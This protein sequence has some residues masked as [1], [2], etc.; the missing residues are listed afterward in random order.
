V[1]LIT[2]T[3]VVET[4][5]GPDTMSGNARADI[6][7]GGVNDGGMD[8]MYGDRALPNPVTIANDGD[9]VLLGDNGLL[10]FTFDGFIEGV[11]SDFIEPDTDRHTLDLIHSKEDGKGGADNIS[12]DKGLD[13]A[14]G[15]TGGDTIYGDDAAASAAAF[16]LADILLGDNADIFLVDPE[17]ASGGDLKVVLDSAVKT[18]KT[19]DEE[20][21]EYG[22]PDTI[23]GNAKGDIIAGGVQGDTLYGDRQSPNPTTSADDGN[24]LI[25]GDNG[26]FE[27]LSNGR[28]DEIEGID[29]SANNPDLYAKFS[30]PLVFDDD[31][32]TL[33]LITTE[34]PTNGGRDAIW[35]DEGSDIV[36]G[37]TDLDTIHGDDGNEVAAADPLNTAA[38]PD[39]LFGDHGRLYPQF[40]RWL[41]GTGAEAML[42]EPSN[43]FNSRNFFA[44]D[45]GDLDGGEGDRMWGEE[46]DDIMVGQQGDDRMWGGSG[47]DD[48]IGGHNVSGGFD[49]ITTPAVDAALDG[50]SMNDL[51]DGG[52]GDDA[53]A[54][55]NTILWRRGDDLSPRFRMLTAGSIYSTGPDDELPIDAPPVITTNVSETSQSDPDDAVGRDIRLVDHADDTPAGLFGSDV[56]AGGADSDV[57]YGQL[58][59]DLMQGDGSIDTADDMDDTFI[60]REIDI[61]DSGINPDTDEPLFFNIP[62]LD[63]DAADYMEGNGGNDLMYGGLGQDDIIGGSST[64]FGLTTEAMRPDGTD[65]IFGGAGS[66]ARIARNDFVGS[67]DTDLGTDDGVGAVPTDDDVS[68]ALEDRHSRDA[69]FI[70][71]D[72]ANVFRVVGN[73]DNFL[74]F[75]YDQSFVDEDRGDERIVV[76]AMQQIDYTLGGAD[77]NGGSYVDGAAD[78]DGAGPNPADNGA[79][80]LIHGESGDDYIFG[81]T[82]S[83]VIFGESDDD[84]IVGGYGNDWISGGTGQDGILG[85]D[86]LILTSRNSTVGEPLYGIAGLR[87]SDLT[88][89]YSNGDALNETIATPGDIQIALINVTGQLKKTADLVPFSYDPAWI[90]TDDEFVDNQDNTPFA[91]DI[92]FGGLGSDWLHGG[93]GDDAIS[94]AEAL[95]HAYIPIDF[96]LQG[97]PHGIMDLGYGALT[98]PHVPPNP[99]DLPTGG[100]NPGDVLAFNALDLDG[101]HLNNRFRA[102]EFFLYDEYDPLRKILLDDDGNLWKSSAQGTAHEFL[103]NFNEAEGVFRAAGDVP[104]ATG[105]QTSHYEAVN[106]DGRDA[107]FGDLGNDWLVGGTGRDDMYGGW[108]ND[109]LNADDN[110]TTHDLANDAPDTHP[111]YEDRAYGGAG[112][113]VL[114]ANTGGDR[115]IDW[116]G[117]YNSYLVPFAP[118]GEAT[119]S[120]TLQPFLPEYLYALSLGDGVDATRYSDAIGGNPPAPTN[121]N[122]NP[123]RNGEPH[124]ELGLVLQKDFAWQAQTGAPADPQAGNIPGGPRDVL[125]TAG[126]GDGAADAFF[127]D[128]G[129]WSVV[130]GAYQVEP[131]ELGQDAASVFFVGAYIPSY[132]EM[133]ATLNAVKPTGGFKSNAYVIFDYQSDTDFK[134][135]GINVATN[136]LEIGHRT[137]AGWVV[138]RQGSVQGSLKSDTDY[139]V[140]LSVNGSAVTLI[141]DNQYTLSYT[142]EPRVDYFGISHGI[143]DGMVGLGAN[144]SRAKID[145]V[146]VQQLP[147]QFTFNR[148]VDFSSGTTSLLRTPESG[149]WPA[150]SD[151]RYNGT[152][153]GSTPAV[154]LVDLLVSPAAVSE[155]SSK[156]SVTSEGGFVFDY[157]NAQRFK[158]VTISAGKVTL[159]HH[160]VKGWYVDATYNNTTLL[161]TGTD[162]TLG[163][164]LKG[165]TVNVTINGSQALSFAY[166]A[167]VGDGS[168]G[169][170]SRT[171]TTSFDDFTFKSDD[172]S[173]AGSTAGIGVQAAPTGVVS[174]AQR[175]QVHWSGDSSDYTAAL[176]W[177]SVS[178]A[179]KPAFPE[180]TLAGFEDGIR[181]SLDDFSTEV[182]LEPL[183]ETDWYVEV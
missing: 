31:L 29:I 156:L 79:G 23:S 71:G 68:I 143:H 110:Q 176:R 2:T 102:G 136:K 91:D 74:Q 183:G 161:K 34:Q 171:G 101:Q 85:D 132:F 121:N 162:L 27:W 159:G 66:P 99:G 19:T 139:N 58:G 84:D 173:L 7:L 135:A 134:F 154:D 21:P 106:D 127:V 60:T 82:G 35:G 48:M 119:V 129:T 172:A 6:M 158:F 120:R 130:Q 178:D 100:V 83:D 3:D 151:G 118:F 81:M 123:S 37:G 65:I 182:G 67:S 116:V 93:S 86:G 155:L 90:A 9:D 166:N 107:I 4:T 40:R 47:N 97:D 96:D 18:I 77:Y 98:L 44:I 78:L 59:N 8:F 141:V 124:G 181:R 11:P 38:N 20:H 88:A 157:Y 39:V 147:P 109:L 164:T 113:D 53:M 13:V 45:T 145:N 153:S 14:I 175:A 64:L 26:A 180:F 12:G 75:N 63:S 50:L 51:M 174:L 1:D 144:N 163:L 103:L 28:L 125:R 17:G 150:P 89:K 92:M 94:G 70:M 42:V 115:L 104:K 16:D 73:A 46:G 76:R 133:L 138:D 170:L 54:G 55:D 122:P 177:N 25:L 22:G 87:A 111:T 24:D 49:E 165:T 56:M 179:R 140:F 36:F 69:D 15:G 114:I 33:D 112:R 160:T 10:D 108:G 131:V 137:Q 57:M 52:T 105:Q 117:E 169:L 30:D 128:S 95:E 126:F 43:G 168:F 80:D 167:L 32:T 152:A 149:N 61:T 148:T 142:F 62:E 146:V 72:N 41:V 5:G